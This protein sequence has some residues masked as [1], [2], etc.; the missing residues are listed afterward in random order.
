MSLAQALDGE[1]VALDFSAGYGSVFNAH[2][3]AQTLASLEIQGRC[4]YRFFAFSH[5]HVRETHLCSGS[6]DCL[7]EGVAVGLAVAHLPL[8]F[9]E[10][11]GVVVILPE[12]CD[13]LAEVFLF[14]FPELL[15]RQ[16]GGVEKFNHFFGLDV[17]SEGRSVGETQGDYTADVRAGH[18]SAFHISVAAWADMLWKCGKYAAQFASVLA[19]AVFKIVVL[20]SARSADCGTGAVIGV[21]GWSEVGSSGR[22]GHE[23]AVFARVTG[24]R[25]ILV[26]SC[27]YRDAAFND[28]VRGAGVVDEVIQGFALQNVVLE[29][30]FVVCV[31]RSPL[32]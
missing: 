30:A 14:A 22:Y 29:P 6:F 19:F 20:V 24:H 17:S 5:H 12:V 10:V 11:D 16:A 13:I 31:L 8:V 27:E 26:A 25:R 15:H 28:P 21:G 32:V 2:A 7:E 23:V 1:L 18:G 3:I 4:I 9:R